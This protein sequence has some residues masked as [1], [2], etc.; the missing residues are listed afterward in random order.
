MIQQIKN[1]I[2]PAEINYNYTISKVE[3]IF[4]LTQIWEKTSD[5]WSDTDFKG[6]FIDQ[7]SFRIYFRHHHDF[8]GLPNTQLIGEIIS[9]SEMTTIIKTTIRFGF[10]RF[11]TLSVFLLA[12]LVF[13]TIFLIGGNL[14]MLI[15]FILML[16]LS[17]TFFIVISNLSETAIRDRY[18]KHIHSKLKP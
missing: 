14:S 7:N 16:L 3:T 4:I 9:S 18:L 8:P 1:W 17:G 6:D 12:G 11:A 15:I 2:K 13:L 5:F 10:R